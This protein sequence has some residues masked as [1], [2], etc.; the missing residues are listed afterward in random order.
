MYGSQGYNVIGNAASYPAYA[1]VTTS[2]QSTYTW[3]A[4]TTDPRALEN[5]GGSSRIA[6][7]W[8]SRTSFSINVNF[9]D[10]QTHDLALYA[11]DWDEGAERADPDHQRR[12]GGR[13]GHREQSRRSRA[14][15]TSSGRSAAMW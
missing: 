13:A 2:G 15:S 3:A 6:A 11:L 14:G 12:H 5:A 7:C 9:T 1:T 10:G 4:S 8:Y